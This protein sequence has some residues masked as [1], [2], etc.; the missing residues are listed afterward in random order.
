M[1]FKNMTRKQLRKQIRTL[2]RQVKTNT[3]FPEQFESKT[4]TFAFIS[5][6]IAMLNC[7]ALDSGDYTPETRAALYQAK[8]ALT[9]FRIKY[10]DD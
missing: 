2:Q 8:H 5:D 9:L 6:I 1:K 3:V 7:A 10:R 4:E